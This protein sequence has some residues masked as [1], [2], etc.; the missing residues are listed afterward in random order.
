MQSAFAMKILVL[1][2]NVT[3]MSAGRS[4]ANYGSKG[5][6]FRLELIHEQI[7]VLIQLKGSDLRQ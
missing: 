1:G 3:K 2:T 6:P 5:R 7:I 4:V